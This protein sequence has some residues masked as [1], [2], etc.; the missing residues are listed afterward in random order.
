MKWRK[1]NA[2][3]DQPIIHIETE[4]GHTIRCKS[5]VNVFIDLDRSTD[6]EPFFFVEFPSEYQDM[7]QTK[8][9]KQLT[10][11]EIEKITTERNIKN[12]WDSM[13]EY[14][15]YEEKVDK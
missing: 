10:I 3:V 7:Y 14:H 5:K 9:T 8:G 4:T 15:Q 1:I 12:Y 13:N 2:F 6:E 11:K